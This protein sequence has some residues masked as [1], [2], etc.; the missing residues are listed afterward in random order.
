MSRRLALL[1]LFVS[2]LVAR[3]E[4][5]VERLLSS[6]TQVY[7]RW[8][9][10]GPHRASYE[11]TAIGQTLQ[12]DT[13]KFLGG[14][15]KQLMDN[16]GTILTVPQ[17]LGGATPEQLKVLQADI[18]EAPKLLPM[19]ADNGFVVALELRKLDVPDGQIAL[20]LP[21]AGAQPKPFLSTA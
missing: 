13:G 19:L 4:E 6:G 18:V 2:P 21:G 11:K 14:L 9:G 3:A 10:I 16:A 12:G 17:L 15:F 20:I 5:P 7:F 1:V 8:D